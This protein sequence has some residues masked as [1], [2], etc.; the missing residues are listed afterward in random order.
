MQQNRDRLTALAEGIGTSVGLAA[1]AAQFPT[2]PL[3]TAPGPEPTTT[4]S[5]PQL[6]ACAM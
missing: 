4:I 6:A 3:G 2:I 5:L 1:A